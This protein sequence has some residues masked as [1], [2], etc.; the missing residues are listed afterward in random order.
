M[1]ISSPFYLSDFLNFAIR[2]AV[3]GQYGF[4]HEVIDAE[5]AFGLE[6]SY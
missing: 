3:G 4:E 1:W 2:K 5:R 6:S